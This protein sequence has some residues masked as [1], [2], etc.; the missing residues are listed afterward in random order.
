[1]SA[2]ISAAPSPWPRRSG[3]RFIETSYMGSSFGSNRTTPIFELTSSN[4]QRYLSGSSRTPLNHATWSSQGTV[5]CVRII[6]RVLG[7]FHHNQLS[8]ISSI[9]PSRVMNFSC[10]FVKALTPCSIVT[11]TDRLLCQTSINARVRSSIIDVMELFRF[12]PMRAFD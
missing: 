3:F 10:R 4:M 2:S 1:M 5:S 9:D 12:S 6:S 11:N 7:S 8:R